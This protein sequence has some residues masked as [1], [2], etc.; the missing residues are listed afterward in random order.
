M[1]LL[2][3]SFL[4][5]AGSLLLS[6]ASFS[7]PH[8]VYLSTLL[9]ATYCRLYHLERDLIGCRSYICRLSTSRDSR[10]MGSGFCLLGKRPRMV[11]GN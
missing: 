11:G 6:A 5:V 10:G 2:L 8:Y 1:V 9:V 3:L 4:P 7:Y